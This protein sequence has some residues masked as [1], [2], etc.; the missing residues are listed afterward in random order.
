MAGGERDEV[1]QSNYDVLRELLAG[2]MLKTS[3]VS[4]CDRGK[5]KA[6]RLKRRKKRSVVQRSSADV[7][8]KELEESNRMQTD[9]LQE[10]ISYLASQIFDSFPEAVRRLA[11]DTLDE[12]ELQQSLSDALTDRLVSYVPSEVVDSLTTYEIV[13]SSSDISSF[14]SPVFSSYVSAIL[15]TQTIKPAGDSKPDECELCDRSWIPLTAHHLVPREV[16]EKAVKRGWVSE[17]DVGNVAWLC[18]A[19]HSFIHRCE[20][21]EELARSWK[22]VTDL[23]AREDVIR[24]VKWISSVR[25]MSR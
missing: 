10:F 8:V 6:R 24:W 5:A 22:T 19:C 12:D 2:Q 13:D 4:E 18:R 11:P 3:Q 21:N 17:K 16:A 7:D 25:W 15:S 20:S 9:H 14:L 23:A 1:Q